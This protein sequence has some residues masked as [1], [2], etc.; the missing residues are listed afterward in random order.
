MGKSTTGTHEREGTTSNG[1][2]GK[3]NRLCD[4][5]LALPGTALILGRWLYVGSLSARTLSSKRPLAWTP[6]QVRH[7]AT[8]ADRDTNL[9]FD[10]TSVETQPC[11]SR[12]RYLESQSRQRTRDQHQHQGQLHTSRRTR[13]KTNSNGSLGCV[14]WFS[15]SQFD[16][17][18]NC[19]LLEEYHP[20]QTLLIWIHVQALCF[21]PGLSMTSWYRDFLAGLLISA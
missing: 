9:L 19:Y 3:E 12:A 18:L 14:P 13:Q 7:R 6:N 17:P 15:Y 5:N 4:Q 16:V 2:A 20:Q 8:P 10:Q 21:E 11:R 1:I